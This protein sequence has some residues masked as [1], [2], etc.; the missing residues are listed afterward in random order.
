MKLYPPIK[1]YK[2][3][4]APKGSV[5]QWFGENRALYFSRLKME[6]HN[7]IDIVAP[8]GTPLYAVE[9]GIVVEVKDSPEGYGKH[10]RFVSEASGSEWTYGHN[11]ENY[12]KVGDEIKRGQHIAD[13]GNTGFVVS[14]ID[15]GGFWKLGSNKWAGT[16][17][18]L[19][20]RQVL[21]SKR[22]KA[23]YWQY[24]KKTPYIQVLNY[25]NGFFGSV[26]FAN[27]F[28]S[29]E[30]EFNG[31]KESVLR[32]ALKSLVKRLGI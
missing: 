28:E 27:M 2:N 5:S 25:D 14:S 18:H 7:G 20:R 6:G 16:H 12:V 31:V 11:S 19:G 23:G 17:L 32:D 1:G 13:M 15:G 26:D 10:L 22:K 29:D 21:I 4:N 24:N 9:D 3:S 8:H 30:K